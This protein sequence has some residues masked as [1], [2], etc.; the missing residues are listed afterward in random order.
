MKDNREIL[1]PKGKISRSI[2]LPH[3]KNTED[4]ESVVM[5]PP[6]TVTIPLR[7]H[8]GA[9]CNATVKAGDKVFVG[10]LIAE[11]DKFVSAPIHSSVSGTVKQFTKLTLSDG[12]LVDA[13]VI[14]SDGEMKPDPKI[15]PIKIKNTDELIA[16]ARQCGLVGLGGAGFPTHVK[17]RLPE[18]VKID[19]L[20]INGAE[21]EPYI[22]AD[23]RCC[24]EDYDDILSGVYTVKKHLNIENV[25]IA[26]ESNKKKA[27]KN[28]YEVA[29]SKKDKDNSVKL[30]E[31]KTRYPQGAEKTLIYT[32]LKRKI[33][34]GK[35]PS[36]V[37]CMV[38]NI[39][40]IAMLGHFVKTG[41]PLVS[42]RV[43]V[44]GAAI[45]EPKNVIVPLGTKI[46][47][48]IN[49]CGGY[50][51]APT[52]LIMGGPM[53]GTTLLDDNAVITKTSNAVL[54]LTDDEI[55]R[56]TGCIHCGR[57]ASHCPMGL[58]PADVERA[59]NAQ[60]GKTLASLN[61][62]YCMECGCCAYSC[63]A[64]RPLAQVMRLAKKELRRMQ[65]NDK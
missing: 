18:E 44:D 22:T 9:P 40:S 21:C 28:L 38:M 41:M 1:S 37:G 65:T 57:C 62:S 48:L 4:Y 58:Y 29:A 6:S 64:R 10:T 11:S 7:Q 35:L 15:R 55:P 59:L 56:P 32:A 13:V 20:I 36:D 12:S 16:A 30:M 43:T 46:I 52:R 53:M 5:P 14:E 34:T 54:A 51:T 27:I 63:P 60:N 8:I 25:I 50:S 42:R 2:Y 31:L 47:D 33:P 39:T 24:L 3:I 49:F 23:Y 61:I 17:F 19:T 26:I 45:K